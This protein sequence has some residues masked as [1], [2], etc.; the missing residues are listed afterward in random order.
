METL[1]DSTLDPLIEEVAASKDPDNL[2][3]IT[4]C[5]PACGGHFLIAAAR[6]IAKRYAAM[7]HDDEEPTPEHVQQAMR[8]VVASC[9]YGVDIKPLAA[10]L[11]KV[12]LWLESRSRQAAGIP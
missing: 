5:D 10:E 12:S 11:A 7:Y 3:K 4:V 2:L 6:R 8:K 1:L 9:I